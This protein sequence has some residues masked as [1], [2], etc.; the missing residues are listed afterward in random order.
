MA[1]NQSLLSDIHAADRLTA[2][3]HYIRH[4]DM[5][6][7]LLSWGGKNELPPPKCV[8]GTHHHC[9]QTIWHGAQQKR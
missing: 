4:E 2:L 8:C 5:K 3:A 9:T 1:D 6:A 7:W